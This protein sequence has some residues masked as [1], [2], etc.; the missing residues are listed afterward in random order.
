[1]LSPERFDTLR[2][3][4]KVKGWGEPDRI[5]EVDDGTVWEIKYFNPAGL[6]IESSGRANF[7][8]GIGRP[9]DI[10]V[11]CLP[12]PDESLFTVSKED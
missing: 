8:S 2:D 10:I 9:L 11:E 5:D 12:E 4:L 3:Q 1:M 7:I 6:L